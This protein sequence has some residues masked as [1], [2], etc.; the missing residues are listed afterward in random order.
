[1]LN[2]KQNE[3]INYDKQDNIKKKKEDKH[4][5]NLSKYETYNQT[6]DLDLYYDE[7]DYN[8][9]AKLS[10]KER[11]MILFKRSEGVRK[12]KQLKSI[13]QLKKNEFNETSIKKIKTEIKEIDSLENE[14]SKE[15]E[16][17]EKE[18]TNENII[19]SLKFNDF[20]R[21]FLSRNNILKIMEND[22]IKL[23]IG[24]HIFYSMD[25]YK[26]G[27]VI[28]IK[29]GKEYKIGSPIGIIKTNNIIYVKD[30]ETTKKFGIDIISNKLPENNQFEKYKKDLLNY[31]NKNQNNNFNFENLLKKTEEIKLFLKNK[32][33]K[34][35]NLNK[36]NLT[37]KQIVRKKIELRSKINKAELNNDFTAVKMLEKQYEALMT[38][39]DKEVWAPMNT[40]R[41]RLECN[42]EDENLKKSNSSKKE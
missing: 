22:N 14:L 21:L 24:S 9:L 13:E 34:K 1:M 36:N 15:F 27:E 18:S 33:I 11:E 7:D 19:K 25:G 37:K 40:N 38:D 23:I 2:D 35:S 32:I 30:F 31:L 17:V 26:I 6:C 4:L 20:K 28:E 5:K 8:K 10:E 41:P 3:N 16:L 42:E 12:Y 39:D 29:E